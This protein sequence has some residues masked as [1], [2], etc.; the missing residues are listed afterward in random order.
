MDDSKEKI[1]NSNKKSN[2]GMVTLVVILS[3]I[4]LIL[5][6]ILL[7]SPKDDK[8]TIINGNDSKSEEYTHTQTNMV[9]IPTND[10]THVANNNINSLSVS[11]KNTMEIDE[12]VK[13]LF[14]IGSEKIRETQY[15]EFFEYEP[16]S[17]REEK[18]ING[19]RYFKVDEKYDNV[20]KQ[21]EEFFTGNALNQILNKRFANVN[22]D[23]YVSVGGATGWGIANI[24]LSKVS[25]SN[26][27]I[28][29]IVKYKD[30]R[31]DGS[32]SEEKSCNLTVKLVN[33]DYRISETDYFE[34]K[35]VL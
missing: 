25:E 19:K 3:I 21:Y 27:E 24:K 11:E 10:S 26:G 33:G 9:N 28:K 35:F 5:L 8:K 17:P 4:I 7:F 16:A 32:L 30:D 13:N 14:E 6:A 29:Y 15:S 20:K 34:L 12:N 22:G 31:I 1:K 18:N 23:L 2:V